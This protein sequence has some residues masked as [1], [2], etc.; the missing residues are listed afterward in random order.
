MKDLCHKTRGQKKKSFLLAWIIQME[1][2]LN[3]CTITSYNIPIKYTAP[4]FIIQFGILD[5]RLENTDRILSINLL[6]WWNFAVMSLPT[7]SRFLDF[8]RISKQYV[9]TEQR[10]NC[11]NIYHIYVW[12][13][14][15]ADQYQRSTNMY[16]TL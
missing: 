4:I 5:S 7:S 6:H 3:T 12:I 11:L 15:F 2:H 9:K 8:C 10:Q 1:R 16:R 13:S 14:T